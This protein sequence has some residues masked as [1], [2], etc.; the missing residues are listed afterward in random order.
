MAME[1]T[2]MFLWL[3]GF[4]G[5]SHDEDHRGWIEVDTFTWT[6]SNQASWQSSGGGGGGGG[7]AGGSGGGGGGGGGGG[8]QSQGDITDIT[9]TKK[10][11][12]ASVPLFQA[13][14]LGNQIDSGIIS[15]VKLDG[16][17]R[18]EYFRIELQKII[19]QK[20]VWNGIGSADVK[21]DVDLNFGI[22]KEFYMLQ[23]NLGFGRG[24]TEFGFNRETSTPI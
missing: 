17:M 9:V 24:V 12:R 21:E 1:R 18:I 6:V 5:E 23:G 14:M 16:A 13:C 15:C 20:V 4:E 7:G 2:N 3:D 11:D 22:F 19:V 10:I 8:T